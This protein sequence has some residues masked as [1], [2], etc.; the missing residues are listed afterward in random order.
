[1]V[2][3]YVR[4]LKYMPVALRCSR[5]AVGDTCQFETLDNLLRVRSPMWNAKTEDVLY[6]KLLALYD[7]QVST[8]APDCVNS[9]VE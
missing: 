4:D 9:Y 2:T 1:V 6:G 3:P 7:A 5:Q 8:I